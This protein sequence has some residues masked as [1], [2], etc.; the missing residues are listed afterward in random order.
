MNDNKNNYLIEAVKQKIKLFTKESYYSYF[1]YILTE[2]AKKCSSFKKK[3][4][5]S[6]SVEFLLKEKEKAKNALKIK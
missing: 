3:T 1:N 5:L 4:V 6:F 2:K